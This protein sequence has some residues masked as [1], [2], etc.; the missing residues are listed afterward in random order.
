MVFNYQ[1]TR[2][3][4]KLIIIIIINIYPLTARVVVAPQMILQPA[5]S[6]FPY[7][8][9]PSGT[10]R[11][12][13]LSIPWCPLPTSCQLKCIKRFNSDR[14][15]QSLVSLFSPQCGT[16]CCAINCNLSQFALSLIVLCHFA[17][18][19]IVI[20]ASLLSHRLYCVILLCHWLKCEPFC[21]VT[22]CN[23]SFCC[24]NDC[25]V[26]FC[27]V[28][29][30]NVSFCYV[31]DCNVSHFAVSLIALSFGYVTDCNVSHFT[32]S[33]IALSFGYVTD[34]NVS[35][36]CITDCNVSPFAVSLIAMCHL[37]MSPIMVWAILL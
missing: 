16:F 23:V 20:W 1:V 19:L 32:V 12:P 29:D 27:Y 26:S 8:P 18:S 3:T 36:C 4:C 30:C 7:P 21:C 2:T 10:C 34:C 28:T 15:E 31:T 6:I 9:L 33:L 13:G 25:T 37:A 17:M 24:V 35:F 11:T 22:D 5:F 14:L